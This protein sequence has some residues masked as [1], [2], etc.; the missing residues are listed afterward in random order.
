MTL[1]VTR[2]WNWIKR[3]LTTVEVPRRTAFYVLIT[4]VSVCTLVSLASLLLWVRYSPARDLVAEVPGTDGYDPAT[5]AN[6]ARVD[7]TGAF[8][9][10]DGVPSPV[11]D[12]WTR[13]RGA[14][15]SNVVTGGPALASSWGPEGPKK[16]WSVPVGDGYASPVVFGGCVYLMDYDV[17]NRADAIRCFSLDD[18]REIWRHSYGNNM[19]RNHGMSRTI[20][21]V[22][23]EHLVVMGPRCHVLCLDTPTG[24]FRWGIDLQLDYGTTE[25]LW[26]TGQCPIID[27]G[28]AIIAA[29]GKDVLMMGVDCATGEVA[30]TT[31]NPNGWNMSHSSVMPMTLLGKPMYV[32]SALGGMAAVSAAPEDRG[33]PL[34]DIPWD[35]KVLAPSPVQAGDDLIFVTAGYGRGSRLLRL[36]PEGTGYR[37]EVV[38]DRPPGEILSCEQQTPIFHD[39]LLYG[40]LPK[41]AGSLKGQFACYQPDGTLVWSSGSDNRFGL[42]PFILADNKFYLLDD[43][44]TLTMADA[45]TGAFTPLGTADLLEGHDAWGPFALAGSRLLLRDMNTLACVDLGSSS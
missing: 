41:D 36:H 23:P 7:L 37:V 20:P 3:D 21:A 13:F 27:N 29:C 35:A 4:V 24:A 16:L 34:F 15:S 26:Y 18:G 19:K 14:D 22:T 1:G 32:Y 39:G 5:A 45:S 9:R 42:G 12:A 31:P 11:T 17:E 44:G 25:P 40:I 30:W 38:Y 10:F 28:Q 6:R 33:T 43:E 8:T 2:R